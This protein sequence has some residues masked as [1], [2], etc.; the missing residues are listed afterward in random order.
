MKSL[1]CRKTKKNIV[2]LYMSLKLEEE[3]MK[4]EELIEELKTEGLDVVIN[5]GIAVLVWIVGSFII[6]KLDYI[7]V[8]RMEKKEVDPSLTSFAKSLL[9]AILYILLV[10]AV[11]SQLGVQTSSLVAIVGAAGLAVGLALQGSLS[12]FAG[13]ILIIIFRPFS[14][15]DFIEAGGTSGIVKDIQIF[16]TIL[17]TLDNKVVVVPN[18][19]LSNNTIINYTKNDI[20]R[21]DL[22]FSVAYSDNLDVAKDI[23]T[24]I[25]SNHEKVL[26]DHDIFV[27]LSEYANSSINFT[28]RVWARTSDHW[29]VYFD[30]MEEVKSEFDI[31]NLNIPFPQMD[32]HIKNND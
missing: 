19:Q 16:S 12:N 8:S 6:K 23:L 30:I 14:V 13:G 32:V 2:K 1:K 29:D 24:K 25:A 7:L 4:L 9:N 3:K 18:A 10:V 21:V 17:H 5:V 28:V 26:K 20:R 15:G 27:R 11:V 31:A 22:K